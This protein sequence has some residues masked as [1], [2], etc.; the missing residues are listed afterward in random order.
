MARGLR[1]RKLKRTLSVSDVVLVRWVDSCG[2]PGWQSAIDIIDKPL[3]CQ[4]VG[5][6]VREDNESIV[7]ALS[8]SDPSESSKPYG[9][10]ILIPSQ[11][12]LEKVKLK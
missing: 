11:C 5:F 1:N 2:Q 3:T 9:D 6:L 10:M 12:V 7:L 4:S 8:R